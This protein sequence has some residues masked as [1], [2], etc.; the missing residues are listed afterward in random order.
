MIYKPTALAL[1]VLTLMALAPAPGRA[2]SAASSTGASAAGYYDADTRAQELSAPRYDLAIDVD[3]NARKLTGSLVLELSNTTGT[4]LRDVVLR[5]YPNFPADIFGDGGDVRMD[6]HDVRANGTA[7]EARYEA[8]RT[9]ARIPLPAAAQPGEQIR[10]ELGWTVGFTPLV[11][12]DGSFAL[13]S[14]YPM[15]AAWTNGWRTDVTR[16]PDRVYA[17]AAVYRARI[18]VP[19]GYS[20]ITTGSTTGT[21]RSGGRTTFETETGIVRE[22]AFSVGRFAVQRA[23]HGAIRVNVYYKPGAGMDAAAREIALYGAASLA[24]FGDR[25]GDYP[26]GELDFHLINARRGFDA[27][28]E[29]PGLIYILLNGRY[30]RQTRFVTAHEVAHQW[31]YG[32]VGNDIYRQPWIDEGFAQWSALLVEEQWAGPAAA[33]RVYQ[34]QVVRL[35]NRAKA[36]CGLAITEYG[37]WN[38]YYASVYGRCAQFLYTLRREL[39][40]EAFFAG[41]RRYYAENKYGVGTTAEVRAALEASSGRD[42]SAMF[43]EW[44]GR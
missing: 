23:T 29:F 40:D 16:F 27:G 6:L 14:Y 13:P 2:D 26:Y 20:V 5:L 43:K 3:V 44:A 10:I 18:A 11:Q 1:L 25:F 19:V 7:A 28:V 39:G 30:T 21:R 9:A 35:A 32:V 15:L 4:A 31:W 42:L 17:P 24:V 33:D 22:F 38:A 37:S 8:A 12:A 36:P 41:I 34:E